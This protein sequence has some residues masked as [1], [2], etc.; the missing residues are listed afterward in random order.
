M[1]HDVFISYST[2]DKTIAD[3][4]CAKLEENKIRI[5]IAPRDVVPGSNFAASIIHAINT[6][7]VFILIWSANTSEHILNEIN[8]A[9][10]QGITIIPFRLQDI[11]PTDEMRYYFGRTH[12]LD[13]INP[14]LEKHI[15]ILK[16]TVLVN[17][18]PERQAAIRAQKSEQETR[19]AS[20]KQGP[21]IDKPE[22]LMPSAIPSR[23]K[24][25]SELNKEI[26]PAS[27]ASA[28]SPPPPQSSGMESAPRKKRAALKNIWIR[29]GFLAI[30]VL[31]IGGGLFWLGKN[32]PLAIPGL[33]TK[34][35][36]TPTALGLSIITPTPQM[37]TII[38]TSTQDSGP[39]T[40]RQALLDAQ[41]GDTITFDPVIFPPDE[42][43][44]IF[45]TSGDLP[46]ISR[47]N[48]T[49]DASNAG[50][51]LNGSKLQLEIG[52]N[53][54]VINS[55]HN[56]V[57]G[58]LITDIEGQGIYLEGGSY[59]MI[60]GDRSIG[61]GPL[62]Q[63]N[64]LSNNYTGIGLLSMSGGNLITG[65]LIGT[66]KSGTVA[67]G[68]W[69]AGISIEDNQSY[70]SDP[71]IIGPDNIIAFNGTTASLEGEKITGGVVMD[72]ADTAMTITGN[73]IYDNAG[74]GIFYNI[75]EAART[76]Y[77]TSPTVL[78]FDL[79]SGLVNGQACENCIVEIFSTDTQDGKIYEGTVAADGS[80]K[81]SFSKGAALSGPYLTAT[82]TRS[83]GGNTT[84]F[85]QATS[86]RSD[87]QIALDAI[88]GEVPTFQT[89]FDTWDFGDLV[90]DARIEAGKL[91]VTSEYEHVGKTLQTPRSD[92]F[93]VEFDLRIL[94]SGPEG[95]CIFYTENGG[96]GGSFK[97]I[98]TGFYFTSG[99][100]NLA[101]SVLEGT[102]EDLA[103]SPFDVSKSNTVTLV[104]LGDQIGAF[105]NGQ[106]AY[107]V[108]DPDVSAIYTNA[109]FAA[110][111]N[112]ACEYDNYK[113]WDLSG[114]DFN[115]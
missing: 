26:Q 12:W 39:G 72:T 73:S 51:G 22:V 50:V 62:G 14:P 21:A 95:H 63:G 70:H 94:V 10:D 101:L 91:I 15:E 52:S 17:L 35:T 37:E 29:G 1:A 100:S 110:S 57:M 61:A 85:S 40:L 34:N 38:V 33:F 86:A 114:V 24:K 83:S 36:T 45:L 25:G 106:F 82:A 75:D 48:I 20:L 46:R 7:K 69:K 99:S 11:Q 27:A 55:D 88:Q 18:D 54:L 112:I 78:Y 64:L 6:C 105:F 44:T 68:N 90:S 67:R 71:N 19:I 4:V 77:S 42:P 98:A 109:T 104:V 81:F 65:N 113:F 108:L 30:L 8:Q 76:K 93:V 13:A 79:D 28:T 49:I 31:G 16:D 53:G 92:K 107:N 58:L 5:W 23:R 115:P 32:G 102:Q 47:G 2:K 89:S 9:F 59:N 41:A 97:S 56:N 96:L 74:P 66:D 84:E 43:A 60:G 80:G 87:I 103:Y 3:A 111:H